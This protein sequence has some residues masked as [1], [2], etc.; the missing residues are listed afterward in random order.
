LRGTIPMNGLSESDVPKLGMR[1]VALS[2]CIQRLPCLAVGVETAPN[3]IDRRAQ[4]EGMSQHTLMRSQD[5]VKR[6]R[7]EPSQA[8][9]F[10]PPSRI[11]TTAA[12]KLSMVGFCVIGLPLIRRLW[13]AK[14][15][16]KGG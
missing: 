11:A 9:Q 13:S 16:R 10:S 14:R 5:P 8:Q 4:P 3:W 6:L 12:L 7:R 15:G 1:R 2:M